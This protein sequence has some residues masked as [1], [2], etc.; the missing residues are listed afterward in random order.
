MAAE[1]YG[2][3]DRWLFSFFWMWNSSYCFGVQS[4]FINYEYTVREGNAS[5]LCCPR[6]KIKKKPRDCTLCIPEGPEGEGT[7]S[8][9]MV[10]LKINAK[11]YLGALAPNARLNELWASL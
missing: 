2:M 5:G 6:R 3:G 7:M 10:K 1:R 8:L 11:G 4:T 9:K